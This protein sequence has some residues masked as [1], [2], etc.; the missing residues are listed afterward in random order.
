M[1]TRYERWATELVVAGLAVL[2]PGGAQAKCK[3]D[4]AVVSGVVHAAG[5]PPDLKR[6]LARLEFNG[7]G[8]AAGDAQVVKDMVREMAA[9]PAS[10]RVTLSTK[11]D[12]GLSGSAA[13]RQAQ[14][15]AVALKQALLPGLKAAG[16]KEAV[17]KG[18]EAAK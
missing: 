8:L 6:A 14:A 13:T 11:A 10:A 5:V 7:T 1:Q 2:L 18:V 17:L 4:C 15:R 3:P 9:L 16:G 12:P